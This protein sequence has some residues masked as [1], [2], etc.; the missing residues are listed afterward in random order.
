MS[1]FRELNWLRRNTP[2]QKVI[3]LRHRW[4]K[5]VLVARREWEGV[6]EEGQ[7]PQHPDLGQ[8]KPVEFHPEASVGFN[9]SS[10]V[11]LASCCGMGE[12]AAPEQ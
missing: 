6:V 11:A 7:E 2:P 1:W 10:T 9:V 4:Y 3:N 5:L 12:T 8:L